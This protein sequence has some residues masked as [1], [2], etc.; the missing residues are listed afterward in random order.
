MPNALHSP[1]A[2][3][4]STS[5]YMIVIS[6]LANIKPMISFY[7][8]TGFTA[9]YVNRKEASYALKKFKKNLAVLG[10]NA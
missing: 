9:V 10:K 7:N 8:G 2:R 1:T 6:K 4:Y 3:T 5:N